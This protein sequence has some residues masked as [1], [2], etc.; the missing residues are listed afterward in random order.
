[1]GSL[2]SH[3]HYGGSLGPVT[4]KIGSKPASGIA[5][6]S[7]KRYESIIR[8]ENAAFPDT[9]IAAMLCISVPRLQ[10][11]K[12]SPEYLA[13]RIQLTHGIILDN[14]SKVAHI[15][16]QRKEILTQLLPPA[17]QILAEEIQR[18]ATNF[19]ERKHKVA[20]AQDLLDREGLF[21]KVSKTEI[22]PVD[23]FDFEKADAESMAVIS[24][25]KG[26]APQHTQHTALQTSRRTYPLCA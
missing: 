4:G 17:L 2:K 10:T 19:A 12:K 9:A 6:R 20:L 13:A 11:I 1:M 22:K 18:P 21:A 16:S 3:L 7:Q 8:L 25:L 15:K 23:M 5:F 26:A 24:A 14:E